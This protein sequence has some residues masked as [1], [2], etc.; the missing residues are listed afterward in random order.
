MDQEAKGRNMNIWAAKGHGLYALACGLKLK[1]QAHLTSG[2]SHQK[3]TSLATQ[4]QICTVLSVG[5]WV[6]R[7]LT[8]ASELPYIVEDSSLMSVW[9]PSQCTP[10]FLEQIFFC[11]LILIT[12][13]FLHFDTFSN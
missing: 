1:K 5:S 4:L 3:C 7:V 2:D 8:A 12:Q 10:F 6:R 13:S 9:E 11:F